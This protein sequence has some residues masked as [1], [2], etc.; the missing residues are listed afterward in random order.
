MVFLIKLLLDNGG[1]CIALYWL[2]RQSAMDGFF[3]ISWIETSYLNFHKVTS[4]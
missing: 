4:D 3:C 2:P 1:Y